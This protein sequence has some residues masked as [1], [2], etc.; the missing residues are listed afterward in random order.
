MLRQYELVDKVKAYD[1]RA[2]EAL[3]DRAYVFAMR[4]HG[5]QKR[6]SGDPYFSH[7]IEVAGI[8][9]GLKLDS[10]TIATG[11]LHDVV[12][13]TENTIEDIEKLF[14]EEVANMVDG[15]TKLTRLEL[16]SEET[17]QAENFRKFMIAM[18]QDVRVLL[19][20]LA[21]R[22]HNMRTL[23]HHP[24]EASRRRISQETMDIFAPLA[25]RIG[26]QDFRD[27][28]EDL[29]FEQLNPDARESILSRLGFVTGESDELIERIQK[30]LGA[31]MKNGGL[32]AL[33][34]GRQ[35]R[36]YSTWRKLQTKD[37]S[38]EHLS[39]M[40]G[41]RIIVEDIEECY[42][43]LGILHRRW[44]TVPGRF[45]D[46][47]STPKTNGYQSIHTTIIGPE[48][49]RVELQIRTEEMHEI[50]ES[51]VAAHWLYKER[52]MELGV[53]AESLKPKSNPYES[54]SRFVELL[55][56]SDNP[57][58]FLEHTKL[59]MFFDQVF[60]FTPKGDII[61]LPM[62]ATPIDFAYSVHTDVG[63][64]CV[65]A[66]VNG[67]SVS[68]YAELHNG[69]SVDILRSDA[70]TPDPVWEGVVAT[71]K[72][73]SA[74]RRSVRDSERSEFVRLGR[75]MT[76][77]I[78]EKENQELTE[79][80]LSYAVKRLNL[81]D[82][83]EVLE[84]VGKGILS[85]YDVLTAVFPGFTIKA[86]RARR[87]FRLLTRT[88]EAA[89]PS[90]PIKGLR[91]GLA[92]HLS[93][94]CYPIP[95]DRIVGIREAGKGVNVHTIDCETLEEHQDTQDDW[96][97]LSWDKNAGDDVRMIGRI[98]CMV[99]HETGALGVLCTRIADFD[100]NIT[101]IKIKERT[102]DLHEIIV[103]VEVEDT[104]HLTHIIAALRASP[105]VDSVR[106]VRGRPEEGLI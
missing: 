100:G 75:E 49:Q 42:Q 78:F 73:R 39:D 6:H 23:H 21:D 37:I 16:S 63:D 105:Q 10:A 106:R 79:K 44:K 22:L 34:T 85:G 11:L 66:K 70:Q 64:T 61:A 8:L 98:R 31:T 62:G 28:L 12:E 27:E 35:K 38:F 102:S 43:A 90:I 24:R 72:A 93:K 26:M 36:P 71:G 58:E 50:A 4:A 1:P 95:G 20:K 56:H 18:S 25:G 5:S 77:Q 45:K 9:T 87:A 81:E 65:G 32:A 68:L 104:Q 15:V 30:D 91:K 99:H 60:C 54:L 86:R 82:E 51:G 74:I 19:V 29:A 33:V 47:I 83:D 52:Q 14:G 89:G 2:D 59:E 94:C 88:K 55:E 69:D 97:D 57:E 84:Q 46:Y 67:V 103:D 96:I 76:A 101:N 48:Q 3:L 17:K 92:V 40:I 41:F 7:P 53:V 80:G 13:D